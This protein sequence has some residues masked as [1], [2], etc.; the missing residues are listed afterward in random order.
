MD[1]RQKLASLADESRYDLSCACGGRNDDHRRRGSDGVWVYPASVPRGGSSVM[2][3]TLQSSACINDCRYCPLRRD[4]DTR[5]A[6]LA[7]EELAEAFMAYVRRRELFGLFL[8]SG[9]VRSPDHTMD[10]MLATAESLR[11]RHGYRGFVH[12]KV[13]PG[14]SDAAIERAMQLASTVSL[15]VEVPKRSSFEKLS[16]SKDYERDIVRPVKLISRLR[17]R[18]GRYGRV[19][20]MTQ[21]IVGASDETDRDI[22]QATFGLY[23]RLGLSRVYFSAYQ[24][25][26]G[27]A[28]IPGERSGGAEADGLTREHRLYQA[29]FLI[30]KY[31]WPLEDILFEPDGGLSLHAD[32]KRRWAEAHPEFFPVRLRSAD[33]QSLLRVPGVGPVTADRILRTRAEGI[34]RGLRDVGLRGKRLVQASPYVVLA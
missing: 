8:T 5:R 11:V 24:R 21:F 29:D 13:I 31:R 17:A 30:R 19:K 9:V 12:L 10:R 3:K 16:N 4:R 23:R 34:L 15:N 1:T 18:G 22:V 14:A 27:D 33:R 7:P 20:Q 2:L 26:L 28:S 6:T 25:G 32:P